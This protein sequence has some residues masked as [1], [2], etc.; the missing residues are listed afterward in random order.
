MYVWNLNNNGS[1]IEV[2][3]LETATNTGHSLA[4][5]MFFSSLGFSAS[6]S[7]LVL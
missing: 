7:V 2:N 3:Y 6:L 4:L 5:T 1:A